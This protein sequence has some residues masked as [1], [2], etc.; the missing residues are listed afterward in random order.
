MDNIEQ[1]LIKL[2]RFQNEKDE[3]H[4]DILY[5]LQSI[6]FFGLF[7]FYLLYKLIFEYR[8]ILH[9]IW[10]LDICF[11][12]FLSICVLCFYIQ[13]TKW[14]KHYTNDIRKQMEADPSIDTILNIFHSLETFFQEDDVIYSSLQNDILKYKGEQSYE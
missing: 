3:Y 9:T 4:F 7:G 8:G 13:K 14:R 6:C 10:I 12:V 11:Y 2:P 1:Y 5:D